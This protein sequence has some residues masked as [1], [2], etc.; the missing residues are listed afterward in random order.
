MDM[1]YS[2]VHADCDIKIYRDPY[3]ESPDEFS[4]DS[5]FLI[6]HHRDFWVQRKGWSEENLKDKDYFFAP[7]EA[8][9]HSGVSLSFAYEG[10][11]PDRRWD[12]SQVGYIAV[13]RSSFGEE[14]EK[15]SDERCK[16]L[17]KRLLDEWNAYLHGE[18]FLFKVTHKASG[19]EETCGGFYDDKWDGSGYCLQEARREAETLQRWAN[20]IEA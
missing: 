15:A 6:S 19:E 16:E 13:K 8:Y 11:F 12:V 7:I 3:P 4:D 2:E 17:A 18:V 9:I 20:K 5:L 14:G 10:N 1:V